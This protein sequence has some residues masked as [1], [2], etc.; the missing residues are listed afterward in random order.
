MGKITLRSQLKE[1]EKN[2]L[3]EIIGELIKFSPKNKQFIEIFLSG[4]ED[5]DLERI[6]REAKEKIHIY[7]YGKTPTSGNYLK[8]REAKKVISEHSKILKA[9][10]LQIADLKLYYVEIC[11]VFTAEFGDIN[12]QFYDSVVNSF[13]NFCNFVIKHEELYTEFRDRIEQLSDDFQGI[14]WGYTDAMSDLYY[15]LRSHFGDWE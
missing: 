1:L 13:L 6:V 9:Y 7:I 5:I 11:N 14:G 10:P 15:N 3:I 4:S 2:E 12:E 8:L